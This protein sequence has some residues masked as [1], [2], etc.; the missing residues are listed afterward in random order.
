VREYEFTA[1][2]T[3]GGQGP[4]A[5][6]LVFA[7]HFDLP[8]WATPAPPPLPGGL[9]GAVVWPT[10][11]KLY[12]FKG[13]RYYSYNIDGEGAVDPGHPQ[14]IDSKPGSWPGLAEAFPEGI[15]T[16]VVWPG[17]HFAYFFKG[18]RYV[19]YIIGQ[20]VDDNYPQPI[21]GNWHRLA[22]MFP[23]G[24]DAV[25]V[26]GSKAYFFKGSQYVEYNIPPPGEEGVEGLP[27]PIVGNWPRLAEHFPNGIDAAARWPNGKIYFFKG[28]Q[29]VKYSMD[30]DQKG[31]DP[32]YPKQISAKII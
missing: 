26:H 6:R 23:E 15:D 32:G 21:A 20:R 13:A 30:Q 29:Y 25:F 28:D 1:E 22:D 8:E 24:V 2:G 31:V 18:N 14:L 5:T 7:E 12:L 3:T 19:R 9:R 4:V 17:N 16:G 11:N 10:N 27:K